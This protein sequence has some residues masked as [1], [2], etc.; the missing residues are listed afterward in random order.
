MWLVFFCNI[1]AGIAIISFQSPLL[2][3]LWQNIRP[4]R[5]PQPLWRPAAQP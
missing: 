4:A 5:C 2:Q 1:A 3:D